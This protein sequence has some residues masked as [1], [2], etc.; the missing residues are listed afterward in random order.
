MH[1]EV[2][3]S[4]S[5]I[6]ILS[7]LARK[8][9]GRPENA[10]VRMQE[11]SDRS[12]QIIENI[13]EIIWAINPNNDPVE[14]LIS[15][16]RR[17][18]VHYLDLAGIPV[19]FSVQETVPPFTFSSAV[20]RNIFL[21]VK[22]VLHNVVKHSAASQVTIRVEFID[23]GVEFAIED[24]GKGFL[25]E[26]WHGSGNGLLNMKK[27]LEEIGATVAIQSHPGCGAKVHL[28]VKT[29]ATWHGMG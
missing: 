26:E 13:G 19:S 16:L 2:G 22:E 28:F 23:A 9:L 18:A 17:Y 4:L 20:R 6:S 25:P 12:G 15:Y 5:E 8:D 14:N 3:S 24:N 29:R 11:I 21:V 10:A 7:E 1:D 27:R